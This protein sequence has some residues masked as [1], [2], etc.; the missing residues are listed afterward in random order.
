MSDNI[1]YPSVQTI[2]EYLAKQYHLPAEQVES[3]LPGFLTT[4]ENHMNSLEKA[5]AE[6][7]SLLV[8]K[9]AHTI[10]G[11][12]LNLGLGECAELARTIEEAGKAGGNVD[13]LASQVQELR[14][15]LNRILG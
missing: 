9:A 13:D 3:M 1:R 7:D 6:N 8:G 14:L 11:A 5:L 2:R 4:L 10:K 12:F 15:Q